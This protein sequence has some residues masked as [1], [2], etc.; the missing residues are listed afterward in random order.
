[1]RHVSTKLLH[2][3]V[4]LMEYRDLGA[5]AACTQGRIPTVAYSLARLREIT[6]DET[7]VL[8]V[9]GSGW[10]LAT[11]EP[12]GFPAC[13]LARLERAAMLP[14]MTDEEMVAESRKGETFILGA[15]TWRI[16][17]P[18]AVA[19]AWSRSS[20]AGTAMIAPVP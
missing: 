19:N 16:G 14:A 3:F 20:C 13:R 10:D 17:S 15:T 8:F 12:K 7:P 2:V 1:M 4:L 9:K 5:V 18:N 6:G 11:I